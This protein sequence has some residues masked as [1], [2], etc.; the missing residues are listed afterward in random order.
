MKLK[1]FYITK[2]YKKQ[3]LASIIDFVLFAAFSILYYF[4]I[5][6]LKSSASKVPITMALMFQ[7]GGIIF[8]IGIV[9]RFIKLH[10]A[11]R[12]EHQIL[13]CKAVDFTRK[14]M[15]RCAVIVEDENGNRFEIS[16]ASSSNV[17]QKFLTGEEKEV[18][19][20]KGFDDK[21]YLLS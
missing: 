3:L 2:S 21:Y 6:R 20:L 13:E 8:G 9:I 11:C 7:L 15:G 16:P 4:L 19:V 10:K 12:R 17:Y 18:K 1:D 5:I 14:S